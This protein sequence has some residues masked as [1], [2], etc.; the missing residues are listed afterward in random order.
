MYNLQISGCTERISVIDDLALYIYYRPILWCIIEI[1]YKY[2][3]I[4]YDPLVWNEKQIIIV[5]K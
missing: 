3:N 1:V 5:H 2:V 4:N